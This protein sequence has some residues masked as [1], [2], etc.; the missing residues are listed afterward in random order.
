VLREVIGQ[1]QAT[2]KPDTT[3]RST[4]QAETRR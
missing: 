2:T 3:D 1:L 4:M